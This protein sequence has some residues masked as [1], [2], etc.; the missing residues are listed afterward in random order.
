MSLV[1][2]GRKYHGLHNR[3]PH[4]RQRRSW[5]DFSAKKAKVIVLSKSDVCAGSTNYAQGGIAGVYNPKD[6]QDSIEAHIK[7]TCIAGSFICDEKVVRYVAEH[8]H[9]SIQWLID[10]GVPFDLKE[11][12]AGQEQSPYHLHRE[13]G[14][15]HRRIFHAEDHTGKSIQETLVQRAKENPNI[16]ILEDRYAIDLITTKKLNLPGNRVLQEAQPARQSR[17]RCLRLK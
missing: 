16:S 14:H 8:A 12:A 13:G 7:D 11:S 15:S 2:L 1:L 9:D 5:S 4:Y 6:D 17:L 3:L 10:A